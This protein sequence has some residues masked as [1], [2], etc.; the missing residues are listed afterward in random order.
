[1]PYWIAI[2]IGA[3]AIFFLALVSPGFQWILASPPLQ[4]LG[5][6]SYTLYLTHEWIIEWAMQDYYN[7]FRELDHPVP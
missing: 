2:Y 1:M 4:F 3:L 7:H 6:I 5:K